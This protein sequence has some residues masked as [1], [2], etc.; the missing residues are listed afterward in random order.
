MALNIK[1]PEAE[2]DVRRLAELTGESLT[3]AMHKSVRERL[4]R[5]ARQSR[6]MDQDRWA[7]VEA[8]VARA[9]AIPLAH[10]LSEDEILGYDVM[11][12]L[13][14]DHADHH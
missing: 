5:V 6:T 13:R 7:R 3:E 4:E 14:D 1:S 12:G 8:I 2:R 9:Q 11:E 10:D